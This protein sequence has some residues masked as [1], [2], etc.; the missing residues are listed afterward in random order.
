MNKNGASGYES[1]S[2]LRKFGAPVSIIRQY[3]DESYAQSAINGL[4][5]VQPDGSRVPHQ[6]VE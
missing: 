1:S 6:P 2:D 3:N 5:R 4:C